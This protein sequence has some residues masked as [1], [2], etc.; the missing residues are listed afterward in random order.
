MW[1]HLMP[2][3]ELPESFFGERP[4]VCVD[5]SGVEWAAVPVYSVPAFLAAE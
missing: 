4:S 2:Y 5:M 1:F 3:T